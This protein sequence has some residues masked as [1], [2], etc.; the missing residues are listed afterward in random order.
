[1]KLDWALTESTESKHFSNFPPS[2]S[3]FLL[4]YLWEQISKQMTLNFKGFECSNLSFTFYFRLLSTVCK[5]CFE[6]WG[7]IA[8]FYW[9]FRE[10][11]PMLLTF[12]GELPNLIFS[13]SPQMLL[14][15]FG[16]IVSHTSHPPMLLFLAVVALKNKAKQAKLVD[17][18]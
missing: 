6:F 1:M 7:I 8:Q 4:I 10:N 14:A 18:G 11:Y 5:C 3:S 12:Y 16:Q 13:F 9:D 15:R 17:N 2:F